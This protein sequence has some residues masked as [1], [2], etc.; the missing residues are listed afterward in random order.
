MRAMMG[1]VALAAAWAMPA[2]AGELTGW[3]E[4]RFGMETAEVLKAAGSDAQSGTDISGIPIVSWDATVFGEQVDVVAFMPNGKLD[5][6]Q[7]SLPDMANSSDRECFA[8]LGRI[9][10]ELTKVHGEPDERS[11][12]KVSDQGEAAWHAIFRFDRGAVITATSS[13]TDFDD[14]CSSELVYDSTP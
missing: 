14:T 13:L 9:I 4:F 10:A 11:P 2:A 6:I 8:R 3:G 12:Q 7:L 1:A 5:A